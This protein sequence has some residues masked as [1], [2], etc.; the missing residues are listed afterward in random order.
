M[1]IL[2]AA[3]LPVQNAPI[4]APA[5]KD[6]MVTFSLK[7]NGSTE[8]AWR[9]VAFGN[10]TGTY[11]SHR[12]GKWIDTPITLSSSTLQK[13]G[14]SE[15][16]V[17]RRD[18]ETKLKN[19]AH[20]GQKRLMYGLGPTEL[21]C[22]FNY[23]DDD[24]VNA[25]AEAFQAIA[26][27]IHMGEQLKHSLRY[28]RLGLDEEIDSLVDEVKRGGAIEIQNIAPVL[29]SLVDDDRVMERVKRKAAHL[30]EGAGIAVQNYTPDPSAR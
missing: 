18:C 12:E 6:V 20:T 5:L 23:S 13:I 11:S 1:A 7:P 10:G 25:A 16:S 8:E 27:T 29:Q 30:L 9:I 28:D 22:T 21:D 4:S 14:R 17:K 19:I 24:G 2:P 3:W 26:V 15:A